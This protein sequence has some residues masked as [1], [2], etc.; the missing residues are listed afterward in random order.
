[1]AAACGQLIDAV[2]QKTLRYV[3]SEHLTPGVKAAR[4]RKVGETIAW[5]RGG[6]RSVDISGLVSIT[7]ARHVFYA[8]QNV[9]RLDDYDPV[10]DIL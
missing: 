4:T 2:R 3:P 1:M 7:E 6:D 10:A 8:R 5:S 9:A